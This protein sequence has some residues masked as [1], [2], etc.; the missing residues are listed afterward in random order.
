MFGFRTQMHTGIIF[1]SYGGIGIYYFCAIINGAVHFEFAN[2]LLAGSVTF[3]RQGVNFCD[4]R[5]YIITLEKRGQQAVITVEGI[6]TESSG[7]PN[8]ELTVL[9]SSEFYVGGVPVDSEAH[10]YIVN[11]KLALPV[12]G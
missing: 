9:T 11:N 5:W 3:S 2:R 7:D 12:A 8:V 10:R 1:F 4:S 6:G